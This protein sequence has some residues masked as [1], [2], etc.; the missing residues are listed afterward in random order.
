MTQ[1]TLGELNK[2]M[3]GNRGE[4]DRVN[5]RPEA[6][7]KALVHTSIPRSIFTM[8]NDHLSRMKSVAQMVASSKLAYGKNLSEADAFLV[9]LKGCEIGLEPMAALAS[10]HIIQGMP[11]LSPQGMLALINRTGELVDLVIVGTSDQCSVT[12]TRENRTPHTEVFTMDDAKAQGLVGKDN[13]KK[14]AAVMLKWRAVAACARVVFPDVIQ[15]LYTQEEIGEDVEYTDDGSVIVETPALP[16]SV[17][18]TPPTTAT[19]PESKPEPEPEAPEV[20]YDYNELVQRTK[21][22]HNAPAHCMNTL[23]LLIDEKDF[24][25]Q[26]AIRPETT[27]DYAVWIVLLYRAK[28]DCGFDKNTVM[29]ILEVNRFTEWLESG[30]TLED[31][32]ATIQVHYNE[33][34]RPVPNA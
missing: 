19:K 25:N 9:M 16:E 29:E 13:W 10:I 12:M 28:S 15:G 34:V 11:T 7:P 1:E 2:Q 30:K 21:F 22:M 5:T 32:W 23:N 6:E 14:Q 17:E 33:L 3:T 8:T 31:A 26:Y 4:K 18:P 27:T 20:K 24:L